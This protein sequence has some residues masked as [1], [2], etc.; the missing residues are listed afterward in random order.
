MNKQ[1]HVCPGCT[2][3]CDDIA[4]DTSSSQQTAINACEIGQS[5]FQIE[6][7]EERLHYISGQPAD[8]QIAIESA[9]K[10]LAEAKAPLICGLEHLSAQAQQTAWKIADKIGAT[11]DSSMSNTGRASSF[12]LQRIGKVTATLGEVANRSDLVVFWFCDPATSHPRLLE[13]LNRSSPTSR[14]I[15]VIDETETQT[16]KVADQ[17]IQTTA[18]QGIA[19]LALLRAKLIGATLDP[20]TVE[21]SSGLSSSELN[22]LFISLSSAAYGAVFHGQ[23]EP[24]SGFDIAT[25]SLHSLIRKLNDV[26]RFV[27][28]KLRHDENSQSAENVLSW[29]TGYSMAVNHSLGFPRFNW[30]EHSAESVLSRGECDAVLFATGPDMLTAI[31]GLSKSARDHLGSIPKIVLS[32]ISNFQSEIAFQIGVLAISENGEL[33]RLDDVSLPVR[34]RTSNSHPSADSILNNI[35]GSI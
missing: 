4:I 9:A 17:F 3:L 35:L 15:V 30:L 1:T 34:A 13:R 32:P 16:A 26:T 2:L 19:L 23:P 33:C 28:L 11:I 25:Q 7:A 31:Q 29:S 12:A 21:E 22:E 10:T 18:D 27:G 6:S 5:Y 8:L 24:D 20:E 14:T